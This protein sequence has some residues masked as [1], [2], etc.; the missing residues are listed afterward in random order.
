MRMNLGVLTAVAA[1]GALLACGSDGGG[2]GGGGA[3]VV[4]ART[5]ASSGNGQSA[6]T[7]AALALPL[8]VLVTDDGIPAAGQT[9][10]W[11]TAN[12]GGSLAPVSSQT[13]VDGIAT[14]SWTMGSVA[15]PQAATATLAGAT[16]SPVAFSA[17]ATAPPNPIVIAATA[18][19]S[20]NAQTGIAGTALALP[21]RVIVTNNGAP[22]AGQTITWGTTSGGSFAPPTSQTGVDG[23]ATSTWTLGAAVVGTQNASATL[24]GAS[25]SPVA[26]TATA[27]APANSIFLQSTLVFSPSAMTITAGTTVTFIWGTGAVGHNVTPSSTNPSAIPTSPGAPLTRNE[28]FAFAVAFPAAGVF[29]F[30]CNVHGLEGA[31]GT[32]SGM[33][34]T[35]TVN[36]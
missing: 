27:N 14:T 17:T 6:Q 13:G 29:R 11:A 21:L 19:Q 26:F 23:I 20:G 10:Q 3:G 30:Y 32:V 1:C 9:V 15:G 24:A 2:G 33:S 18:A 36:P 25:G 5:A 31:G 22:F 4:I 8:R 16:G 7:G 34:G 12:P 35:I 28:P